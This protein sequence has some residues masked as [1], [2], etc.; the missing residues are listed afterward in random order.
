MRATMME[1]IKIPELTIEQ[2][3][4]FKS[5]WQSTWTGLSAN[6][7][8]LQYSKAKPVYGSWWRR[9][10]RRPKRWEVTYHFEIKQS[11]S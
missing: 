4:E 11:W 3:A 6:S 5:E 8:D 7:V 1:P 9:L 2:I 10:L